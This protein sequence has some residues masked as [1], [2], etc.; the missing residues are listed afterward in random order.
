MPIL[1]ES[2]LKDKLKDNPVGVYLVYGEES[3]LKKT[4]VDK[5]VSKTVDPAFED[6]N[7]HVFDGKEC[8][9]SDVYESAEAVPMMA[10]TKCVLVK[11]FPLDSLDDNGFEQLERVVSENPDDCALIFS[12]VAYEPKGAKWNKAVKLFEKH[13]YAVKLDKK[14]SMELSK[15]LENG[16]KKRNKPFEKG[17]A[18]YLITCVGSDLNTLLNEMEKVCAYAQGEEVHR[19]DVDAVCIK[20]LDAKVFDMIKDLTAGRFDSAFRKLSL[21]FEQR[22][23]EFQILGALIAQYSDIYRAKA[24]VKSGN[25]AEMI[26][27]YYNYA[28]KEFRLTNAARSGSSLSF[29]AISECVDI[30]LDA[31]TTMKSTAMSKRLVLEQTVVKLARAGR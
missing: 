20:S 19:S 6:F 28:G 25:R 26:A 24:A 23:D 9:L 2:A 31:D 5:I 1:N 17:V 29:E 27:K 14:T 4:Y 12:F 22:E 13:G 30:L 16:A 7:F 10:E 3:Y 11:D 15:M 18:Q 21:L 8:T